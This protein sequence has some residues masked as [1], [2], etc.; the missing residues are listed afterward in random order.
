MSIVL[1]PPDPR[2]QQ[3]RREAET[4]ASV[5]AQLSFDKR[6]EEF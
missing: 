5:I 2:R 6:T 1:L 3:G 4:P